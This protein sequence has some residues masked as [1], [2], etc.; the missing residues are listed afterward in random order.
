MPEKVYWPFTFHWKSIVNSLINSMSL[1]YR[2][3]ETVELS[4]PALWVGTCH[5]YDNTEGWCQLYHQLL[6]LDAAL[7]LCRN[8]SFLNVNWIAFDIGVCGV[9]A[10]TQQPP[11]LWQFSCFWSWSIL[12]PRTRRMCWIHL[13]FCKHSIVLLPT[14]ALMLRQPLSTE[15]LHHAPFFMLFSSLSPLWCRCIGYEV[16]DSTDGGC[17][18]LAGFKGDSNDYL[19]CIFIL[20]PLSYA[21]LYIRSPKLSCLFPLFWLWHLLLLPRGWWIIDSWAWA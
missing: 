15:P 1:Y 20:P 14:H 17:C 5:C 12:V 18:C 4:M 16:C 8:Y 10:Y 2:Q 19:S 6:H 9:Y 21:K 13:T 3:R 7:L 11:G